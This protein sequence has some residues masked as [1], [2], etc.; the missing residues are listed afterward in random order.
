MLVGSLLLLGF[1]TGF[2]VFG[3]IPSQAHVVLRWG[4]IAV[5][6]LAIWAGKRLFSWGMYSERPEAREQEGH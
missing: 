6:M 4:G 2:L 3:R 1:G 5:S